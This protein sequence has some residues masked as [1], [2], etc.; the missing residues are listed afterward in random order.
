MRIS[1]KNIRYEYTDITIRRLQ[2]LTQSL[3]VLH[4]RIPL[5]GGKCRAS[6]FNSFVA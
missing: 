5:I 2:I 1:M 4:T 6:S 3:V